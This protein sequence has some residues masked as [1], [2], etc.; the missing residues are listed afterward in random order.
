MQTPEQS[1]FR[2]TQLTAQIQK[3][4]TQ[5]KCHQ[6][7]NGGGYLSPCM[8]QEAPSYTQKSLNIQAVPDPQS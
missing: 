1:A 8:K 4:K 5:R 6:H 7:L 3:K 2:N